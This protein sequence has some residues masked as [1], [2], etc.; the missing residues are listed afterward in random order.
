MK[1]TPVLAA[2]LLAASAS[3]Q[4]APTPV[5]LAQTSTVTA[6]SLSLSAASKIAMQTVENC[7]ALGYNV[8]ATVVDRAGVTLAVARSE[9]AGPHT[10]GAS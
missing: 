10:V 3:A 7:A 6:V 8:T 4:T 5:K 2:L 9:G 1:P